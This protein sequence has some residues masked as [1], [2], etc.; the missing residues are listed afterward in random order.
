MEARTQLLLHPRPAVGAAWMVLAALVGSVI[1]ACVKALQS[2]FDTPQIVLLRLLCSLPF[3][4]LFA[5]LSGGLGSIRPK[6]PGWHVVRSLAAAG[7]T[8]GFF[9][10]LGELPL[11]LCVTIGFAAPLLIALLSRPFLGERVGLHRWIGILIGFGGVLVALQPGTAAWHPAMLAVLASTLCWAVLALS[12]RKIGADEP[13]GAMVVFTIPVSLLVALVL[14][15]GNWVAPSPQEW[16]LF[17]V[18]G[19][20]GASVHYCVIYA[21]RATRAAIVAPMEYTALLWAAL[22]GFAFWGE[23]PSAWTW[24]GAVVIIVGGLIVLR[25]RA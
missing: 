4:L 13:T 6:R 16:L 19:F 3:V 17:F 23:I 10:A 2:G 5:Q 14:T 7:A 24:I 22:L 25:A 21:Y 12:A 9:Y 8:F 15:V 11:M 20:C 1:D 18:A